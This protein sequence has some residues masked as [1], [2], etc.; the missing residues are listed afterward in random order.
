[1]DRSMIDTTSGG[2]LMNK[3]PTTTRNL[4][5]NKA[6][7]TQQFGA[8]GAAT[9]SVVTKEIPLPFPTRTV[10]ARKFELDEEL[11]Q[12]F[13][14]VEV[15]IP[16]L[17]AI[18]QIL[19]YAKFLKELCT[20]KRN[21]LKGD[22]EMGRNVSALIK[23]EQVSALIQPTMLKKC[24]DPGTFTVLC[25]IGECTFADAMLDLG[26]PINIMPS[27]V[28]KSL[29][30]SDLES[31]DVIIQLANRSIM[32]PL[33]MEDKPS[34]KGSTLILGRPFLMIARTKI[35][36]HAGT[37]FMEFCD[38]MMQLHIGLSEFSDFVDVV[39]VPDFSDYVDVV[40]VFDFSD[41]ADVTDVSNFANLADFECMC[42]RGKECSICVE[43]RVA[44]DEGPKV[45][46]VGEV[47][48][49]IEVATSKPPS[50][51]VELKPLLEHLKYA[52]LEDDQKLQVIIANNLQSE[53]EER[54]LHVLRKHSKAIGWTLADLPGINPSICMHRILLEEEYR[55]VMQPQRQLNPTILDVVKKKVIKLLAVGIIYP[56]SDN[57]WLT[58][59][60]I[61]HRQ[62]NKR[63]PSPACS[64][65]FPTLGCH[66]AY[67]M[68][69]APPKGIVLG[70]LVS[71]RGIEVDKA[72]IDIIA[73]LSHPTSVWEELKKRL[74]TTPILQALDWELPFE[75]MCDASNL[76]LRAIL[77]QRVGKHSHVI[78]YASR[79]LD[80][81]QA[82]YTT[83]ENELLAIVTFN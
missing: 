72:K 8:R 64:A 45:A 17:K 61:L 82:Y 36:V 35:D 68:P 13:R 38:N 78:A 71:N 31:F 15:N 63:P 10:H 1:M 21:K 76:A 60:F 47:G 37:L 4:I 29:N 53:Q 57:Q 2:A 12:T 74:T 25:T 77:G 51:T 5:S 81:A 28:Y 69:Q 16:L 80:S 44:I 66:L 54:L 22:V 18:K 40:D 26:T 30:F 70:H 32:H 43:I 7:N 34:S 23:N 20:H 48:A 79:T 46:E 73:S 39:D 3:T 83:T 41:F 27:S 65:H 62:I 55:L 58:C 19:K 56:I 42:D 49:V 59:R 9:S 24:R 6:S 14:K 33:D 50:P 75:L 52:Y 67:A 11:L